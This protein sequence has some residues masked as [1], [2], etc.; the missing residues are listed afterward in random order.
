MNMAT[1]MGGG[2]ATFSPLD[3]T[4]VLLEANLALYGGGLH[5][6]ASE[7]VVDA[8]RTDFLYNEASLGGGIYNA[9]GDVTLRQASLSGNFV[10]GSGG[11]IY[12]TGHLEALRGA[13]LGNGAFS[14]AGIHSSSTGDL[15]LHNM[16]ISGNTGGGILV[17]LASVADLNNVTITA[18]MGASGGLST[19]GTTHMLNTILGG[20]YDLNG[21]P[22]D[23]VGSLTSHGHN[24]IED[25]A[26]CTIGGPA[27]NDIHATAPGLEPLDDNGGRTAT[28]ALL[29][30]SA[31]R[32]AGDDATCRPLDQRGE[33]RP[34]GGTC[35]IGAYERN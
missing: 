17:D 13:I 3:L 5:A 30:G 23:C 10:G 19:S 6:Y 18:N 7:A 34:L 9:G 2:I 31:A 35:D 8:R 11:G 29:A 14:G 27:T 26:A 20:N 32:N 21:A 22:S 16:T 25:T 15:V 12:N 1:T 4:D 28:H 33:P 24:L